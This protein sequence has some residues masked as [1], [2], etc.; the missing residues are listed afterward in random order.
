MGRQSAKA[1]KTPLPTRPAEPWTR[2]SLLV[3]RDSWTRHS[4]CTTRDR[5]TTGHEAVRIPE[6]TS[7]TRAY[8]LYND[9]LNNNNNDNNNDTSANARHTRY[10]I[11]TPKLRTI[12]VWLS[13]LHAVWSDL[14]CFTYTCD[15]IVILVERLHHRNMWRHLCITQALDSAIH[16]TSVVHQ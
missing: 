9:R 8:P 14:P 2:V 1:S 16:V 7:V 13:G 4:R 11:T 6:P 12:A 15:P 3:T 10:D 5:R